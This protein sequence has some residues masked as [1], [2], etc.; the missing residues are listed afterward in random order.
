MQLDRVITV[1]GAHAEGEVGRVI[2]GGV[3]PPKG[4]TMFERMQ[5][6][7]SEGAWLRNMLLFDPRGSVNAAVNLITPPCRDDAD[8]GMIVME[9]DYFV[10]MSGSN[11]IC[12]VTVALEAGM[13]PMIEPQTIVRVDT[14]A[15]LVEV[16]AECRN[17][18][19]KRIT[20]RNI[21]S[22]V[23]HR[24]AT[25]DVP[26][27]GTL[28]VDVAYGGMIYCIVDAEDLN[29]TLDS[30]EAR[31]LVE[32]GEKIKAAAASQLPSI[33]PENPQIHTINQVE[34]AGPLQVLGGVRTSKNAVVVSPGR[35][36]RCPCGT[37]TSARMALLHARGDLAVGETFRHLSILDTV[38]DCEILETGTAGPI[39]AVTPQVSGRAWLTGVSHYGV[40]PED[41][42]PEGYR[43]SDT[44]FA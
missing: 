39:P 8:L 41:P 24:D 12:T 28:R 37:G 20:F 44:W 32:L 15:G 9:S 29:L 18:K 35:L 6:L 38:F 43:L 17:G 34:F 5:N 33:H 4:K 40:D 36:D 19:C 2:T 26:D 22:F 30:S 27:L 1:V 14:P 7:E 23:M 10:P 13:V 16:T 42:F 3:L 11:L 25:I 21:P 31:L